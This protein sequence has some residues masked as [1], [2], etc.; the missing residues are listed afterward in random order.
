MEHGW[1]GNATQTILKIK[2]PTF[3]SDP[4]IVGTEVS[5]QKLNLHC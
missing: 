2:R 3:Q 4:K 5:A 1:G